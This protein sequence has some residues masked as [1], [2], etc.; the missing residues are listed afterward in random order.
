[1]SHRQLP[2]TADR[3]SFIRCG[4]TSPVLRNSGPHCV[5]SPNTGA[6]AA[7]GIPVLDQWRRRD[8]GLRFT[9]YI[10]TLSLSISPFASPFDT[11]WVEFFSLRRA[12]QAATFFFAARACDAGFD[13]TAPHT[14]DPYGY[15]WGVKTHSQ[16]VDSIMTQPN[17]TRRV[18]KGDETAALGFR[19]HSGAPLLAESSGIL[20]VSSPWIHAPQCMSMDKR[21]LLLLGREER[22]ESSS[23]PTIDD[24]SKDSTT[25]R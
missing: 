13:R 5:G 11:Y 20:T 10:S 22:E 21:L 12:K 7:H 8:W 15:P 25:P 16:L 18:G 14:V 17:S 3:N 9:L 4:C 6:Q 23:G 2:G 1:M 19:P 24:G